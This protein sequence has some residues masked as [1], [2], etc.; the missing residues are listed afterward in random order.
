MLSAHFIKRLNKSYR[1]FRGKQSTKT[2]FRK[3]SS[4]PIF[5][6]CQKFR[7][8]LGLLCIGGAAG[9][10]FGLYQRHLKYWRS[11]YIF[12]MNCLMTVKI[13]DIPTRY[14][15]EKLWK[16]SIRRNPSSIH[17]LSEKYKTVPFFKEIL[18]FGK[19]NS[20]YIPRK[21]RK[22]VLQEY[23]DQFKKEVAEN[24]V[25][26]SRAIRTLE[27]LVLTGEE[28]NELFK[29]IKFYKFIHSDG[30]N[31]D[32]LYVPGLNTDK[33]IFNPHCTCC[34][35]GLYFA[36]IRDL[37]MHFDNHTHL[38]MVTVPNK[39]NV[40]TKIEQNKFKST[41]LIVDNIKINVPFETQ[42]DTFY[43]ALNN[44]SLQE[45]ML[46]YPEFVAK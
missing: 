25:L 19:S 14:H 35:G 27:G 45:W 28:F 34:E 3:N 44:D 30:K 33:K 7:Y 15:T 41:E 2:V 12:I 42:R 31:Y 40:W 21:L 1:G 10:G 4:V 11:E 18:G 13:K 36:I 16:I 32:H 5:T 43:N 17:D 9:I 29:D 38:R 37:R 6:K 24:P 39:P 46:R 26:I 22:Q 23:F 8:G 20:Y